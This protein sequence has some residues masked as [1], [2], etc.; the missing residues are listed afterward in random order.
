MA[1]SEMVVV[2]ETKYKHVNNVELYDYLDKARKD[3]YRYCLLIG[4]E[5]VMVNINVSYKKEV[6]LHDKLIIRTN[7]ERLGNT[8]FTLKQ[9]IM[10]EMKELIV[11]AESVLAVIDRQ[12]RKK[13]TLPLEVRNLFH[14]DGELNLEDLTAKNKKSY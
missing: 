11:S 14:Y 3:W 1:Y 13:I 4:A 10:N 12:S 2:A 9:T 7:M 8:S 5:G 6:F